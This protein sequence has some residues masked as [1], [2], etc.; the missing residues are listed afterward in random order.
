[1]SS[2]AALLR[3]GEP[4]SGCKSSEEWPDHGG[5]CA[6]SPSRSAGL[7]EGFHTYA[8]EWDRGEFR[9]CDP[10]AGTAL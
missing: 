9:W 4:T 10:R 5:G 2:A 7:S 8:V 3:F 6:Y 1:M